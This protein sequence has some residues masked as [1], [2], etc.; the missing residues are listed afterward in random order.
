[1]LCSYLLSF[2]WKYI[3]NAHTYRQY[4]LLS[5]P[6]WINIFIHALTTLNGFFIFFYL[7]NKGA[8]KSRW[9]PERFTFIHGILVHG[10]YI[11]MSV[12]YSLLFPFS[13]RETTNVIVSITFFKFHSLIKVNVSSLLSGNFDFLF[14]FS[15]L[16][17]I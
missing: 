10:F 9:L 15:F 12:Y 16:L 6:V 3:E 11:C 4:H 2:E 14:L 17:R 8:V 1:M 7:F 5:N 13:I